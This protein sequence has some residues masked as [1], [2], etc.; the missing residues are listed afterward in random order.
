[1][2]LQLSESLYDG[3]SEYA[4]RKF[5]VFH[6]DNGNSLLYYHLS[7]SGVNIGSL[8]PQD[9]LHEEEG[10]RR[11]VTAP[12]YIITS[13]TLSDRI[14]HIGIYALSEEVLSQVK[15]HILSNTVTSPPQVKWMYDEDNYIRL[16]IDLGTLPRDEFYPDILP[17]LRQYYDKYMK[18]RSSVIV[19]LGP[20]GTGKT[21][22]IKGLI[23][24][25]EE[26]A[27]ISYNTNVLESDSIF[28][29]FMSGS[30]RFM[31]LEDADS[32][33]KS[34]NNSGNTIMHKF[35][36][37]ADGLV[38]A[39]GKKIIFSTNLPTIKDID[40]ALIRPGRCFDIV[41]FR[42]LSREECVR[43]DPSYTGGGNITLAE[44]LCGGN[45]VEIERMGF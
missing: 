7:V 9:I 25:C 24:H 20:P 1:M 18:S 41:K 19:L 23:A 42:A 29:K 43:V 34:R 3:Y 35:L 15:Q 26:G 32:F 37:I 14:C 28:A 16:P 27:L 39:Q 40:T 44:L 8:F 30:E 6:V 38:S 36:N 31:V 33:L 22:F 10:D 4:L 2:S 5:Q 13:K 45:K 11:T 12:D 17:T 21:S